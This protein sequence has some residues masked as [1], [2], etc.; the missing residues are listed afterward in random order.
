V[1]PD[2]IYS[3]TDSIDAWVYHGFFRHLH[4]YTT[5]MFRETYYGSRLG[6]IVPGYVA[7]TVF[8]P[9]VANAVLHVAT[10]LTA[11]GSFYAILKRTTSP[12]TALVTTFGFGLYVPVFRSLGSDYVD[13]A[14][15]A[16]ALLAVALGTT[17]ST[18]RSRWPTFASG[19]AVGAMLN[20]NVGSAL[21]VPAI[22]VWIAPR[23]DRA[24]G[25]RPMV[26]RAMVWGT[27]IVC[28]TAVLAGISVLVGGSWDFFLTSFRWMQS[29]RLSNPWDV[30]GV[31]WVQAAPW[32]LLP[33]AVTAA[34]VLAVAMPGR[35][36]SLTEGQVR[37]IASF[38]ACVVIFA[39][40]DFLG[41]GSLLYWP[42]YASWLV[43]WCFLVIGT[44]CLDKPF[45]VR[46]GLPVL[47]LVAVALLASLVWPDRAHVALGAMPAAGLLLGL[48][49]VAALARSAATAVVSTAV[50]IVCLHGWLAATPYYAGSPDRA[51]GFRAIDEGVR[52]IEK[53]V[54]LDRPRFLLAPSRSLAH[55]MQGLTSVYLWGYTIASD[56]FPAVSARQAAEI[57]PGLIAIV[58]ADNDATAG[59]F[60]EVFKPYGLGGQVKGTE[61]IETR[62]GPLFLTFLE[63][64]ALP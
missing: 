14:V 26:V 59:Q 17:R 36:R 39:I 32:V 64:R 30:T 46:T 15:I 16:D 25:L 60:D 2:W 37:A 19:I 18:E 1:V 4:A 61:R 58:I 38:G 63:A 35:R 3:K 9:L 28:C 7:Y 8:P 45:A 27:G 29:Q 5:S 23:P 52:A 22:L 6:W 20:S 34:V 62:H 11:V 55:Y 49:A 10:F 57:S 51:D 21:L 33:V 13:G 47:A 54:C 50:S 44:V 56:S 31:S 41:S 24:V 53:Y 43:P 12:A 48:M 42:Y 40:W